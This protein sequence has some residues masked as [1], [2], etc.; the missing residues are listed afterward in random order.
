M[1]LNKWRNIFLIGI[2]YVKD[3]VE[4]GIFVIGI[5]KVIVLKFRKIIKSNGK[6]IICDIVKVVCIF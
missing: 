1:K 2:E 6:C 4:F 5:G 3:V